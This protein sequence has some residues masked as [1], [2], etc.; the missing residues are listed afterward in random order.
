MVLRQMKFLQ[1]QFSLYEEKLAF[2][3]IS[4][5]H[6]AIKKALVLIKNNLLK[7]IPTK[8]SYPEWPKTVNSL[9]DQPLKLDVYLVPPENAV[10]RK[11]DLDWW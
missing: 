8:P 1:E 10:Q 9:K 6:L 4:A 11:K 7:M 5:K 3:M 2:E